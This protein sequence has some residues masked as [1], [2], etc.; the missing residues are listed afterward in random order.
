MGVIMQRSLSITRETGS[1]AVRIIRA[2]SNLTAKLVRG[3]DESTFAELPL[4]S[5]A[6]GI[7][8]F[9]MTNDAHMLP[10]GFYELVVSAGDC[11][12]AC[13]PVKIPKCAVTRHG[14]CDSDVAPTC[15]PERECAPCKP[16]EACPDE[17]NIC[18]IWTP[19]CGN[20]VSE[21]EPMTID[22]CLVK[23]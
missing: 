16:E 1:L 12:C 4:L 15:L 13:L 19:Q 2:E 6:D 9:S 11:I 20:E 3:G 17:Q 21:S 10:Y 22:P 5:Q 18:D 8:S 23:E 14:A 7:A